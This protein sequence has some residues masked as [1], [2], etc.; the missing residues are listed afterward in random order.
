M[1]QNSYTQFSPILSSWKRV[2]KYAFIGLFLALVFS[3]IQPLEYSATTKVA[4][5]Q[6]IGGVDSYTAGRSAERVADDLSEAMYFS[7]FYDAIID[8][9]S[10]ID[11]SYFG[12]NVRKR[13][14][15][16]AK[17]VDTSVSR[18]NGTLTIRAFHVNS[19][20]AELLARS[21]AS[22][23]ETDGWRYVSGSGSI[24]NI[25]VVDEVIVS[26]FPVR[27]NILLNM[28]SGFVVGSLFA[29]GLILLQTEHLRRKHQVI[30]DED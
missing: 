5:T 22:Y 26:R 21:L 27:P 28:F 15:K 24:S 10:D 23:V 18:G 4:I 25:R 6:D 29:I 14:Q 17:S 16:W 20:Q 12:D 9:F 19:Q 30:F 7:V 1:S 8:N 2:L 13:R 3:V 11:E